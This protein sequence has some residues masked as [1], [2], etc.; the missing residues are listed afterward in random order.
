MLVG[1]AATADGTRQSARK[2]S[3]GVP[4]AYLDV[5]GYAVLQRL[6]QRLQALRS[7]GCNA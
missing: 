4:I 5:L 1:G 3:A 7:L 2:P 6:L